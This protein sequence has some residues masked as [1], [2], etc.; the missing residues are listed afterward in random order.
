MEVVMAKKKNF[1]SESEDGML[2]LETFLSL[3]YLH[4]FLAISLEVSK[5]DFTL[6]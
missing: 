4:C 1:Q 6:P 3:K 2:T 5:F